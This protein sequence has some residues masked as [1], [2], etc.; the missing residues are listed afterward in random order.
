RAVL[1]LN[2]DQVRIGVVDLEEADPRLLPSHLLDPRSTLHPVGARGPVPGGAVAIRVASI[3]VRL[4]ELAKLGTRIFR[5][6]RGPTLSDLDPEFDI[7]VI[8]QVPAVLQDIQ[9][10]A[11]E[12][13]VP[14]LFVVVVYVSAGDA[15][16]YVVPVATRAADPKGFAGIPRSPHGA[17][18][19]A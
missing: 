8:I 14:D 5:V 7:T 3:L 18:A 9:L 13:P 19:T 4:L 12:V 1:R 2:P 6:I 16:T 17:A 10:V 11:V 15:K